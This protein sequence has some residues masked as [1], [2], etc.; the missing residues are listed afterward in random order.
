[1][2]VALVALVLL[3]AAPAQAGV[4]VVPPFDPDDYADR[5]AVG[6]L[7][8]GA[9]PTVT[10]EAA[11]AAL[12]RGKL[13]HGLLG[14]VAA[15]E[16][17][18]RLGD[19]AGP[20]I[21]VSLPPPGKS[22]NDVRY[23]IALLGERGLLT[24][25]STRIDGL[26]SVT[27]VATGRLRVV[28]SDDPAEALEELDRRIERN[29]RWRLPLTIALAALLIALAFVRPRAALRA[30]LVALAANLWLS[31]PLAL[32]AGLAALL[33]P[34]G[35]GLRRDARR[36]PALDGS[37][38]GDRRALPVRPLSVRPLLRR[39]QPARDDA[40]RAR[41]RRRGAARPRPGS[42]SPRSPSWRSAATASAPTAAASS[43]SPPP[44][45]SSGCGCAAPGR[46][47]G[48]RRLVAAGAVALALA[49]ARPRRRH[50]RLEPRHRCRRRRARRAG[51]G[52]RRPDR[53]LGSAHGRERRCDR[54]RPRL[55][56][57]PRR[58]RAPRAPQPRARRLPR[59]HR[60]L[61]RRQRHA[62]RRARHGRCDR[63]RTCP[64]HTGAGLR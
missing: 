13:E 8:P 1:M 34:L 6:L 15:G 42:S 22:E 50:R 23:P 29:D 61:A 49:P 17:R 55:A 57:D 27:D 25:D 14:G 44:T 21:L 62:Q 64:V 28:A 56:R 19:P 35:L 30:L 16:N 10:R 37:R 3:A 24:S 18:I 52:R 12:L 7:V 5:A 43:S 45:S 31:P 2:R 47:G 20:E 38:R 4:R 33:L 26:V 53:A 11:L 40:A 54:R 63:D 36:V 58:G 46:P 32:A 41:P 60:G 9:G 51:A 59:R 39:Q 48:S